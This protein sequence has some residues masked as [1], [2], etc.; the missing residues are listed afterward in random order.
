MG[1]ELA[2]AE[3]GAVAVKVASEQHDFRFDIPCLGAQTLE[4]CRDAKL[5]VL[6]FQSGVT[7]LLE[8]EKVEDLARGYGITVMAAG[9]PANSG[10]RE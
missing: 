8:R 4:K 6:A 3:G 7:L 5:A 10:S 1:G 9:R 2:G